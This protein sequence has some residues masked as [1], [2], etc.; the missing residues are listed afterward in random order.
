M[1][2]M[3]LDRDNNVIVWINPDLATQI[4]DKDYTLI[5]ADDLSVIDVNGQIKP[6]IKFE[7]VKL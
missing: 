1:Q 3:I 5:S 2:F 6:V 4:V 7:V